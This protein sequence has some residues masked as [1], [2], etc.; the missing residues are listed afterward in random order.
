MFL[1]VQVPE[2]VKNYLS[3]LWRQTMIEY[4]QT[5]KYQRHVFD[6]ESSA[7]CAN[8]ALKRVAIDDEDE[9]P[10]AAKANQNNLYMENLIK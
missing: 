6:A 8:Y 7:T 5:F 2:R 9:F 4:A 3:F 10:I 1:Q